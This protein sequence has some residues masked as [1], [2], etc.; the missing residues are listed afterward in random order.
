MDCKKAREKLSFYVYGEL[1]EG[2]KAPVDAHLQICGE[3]TRKLENYRVV[4]EALRSLPEAGPPGDFLVKVRSR[5]EEPITL[6]TRLD[7]LF[8][9]LAG[10]RLMAG[11]SV[12]TAAGLALLLGQ[13]QGGFFPAERFEAAA[14]SAAEAPVAAG[15]AAP[16]SMAAGDRDRAKKSRPASD[17]APVRAQVEAGKAAASAEEVAPSAAPG[18]GRSATQLAAAPRSRASAAPAAPP[19]PPRRDAAEAFDDDYGLPA[20]PARQV[21]EARRVPVASPRYEAPPESSPFLDGTVMARAVA[22]PPPRRAPAEVRSMD[23]AALA[24]ELERLQPSPP[25][26]PAG[27]D[28]SG[29]LSL[30]APE[31]AM[32]RLSPADGS[33]PDPRS[34]GAGLDRP[35]AGGL[36]GEA[37]ARVPFVPVSL[38]WVR[39]T[40]GRKVEVSSGPESGVEESVSRTLGLRTDDPRRLLAGLHDLVEAG[41]GLEIQRVVF[42]PDEEIEV[43]LRFGGPSSLDRFVED[44]QALPMAELASD[45]S[46]PSA[47]AVGGEGEATRAR[48]LIP[49]VSDLAAR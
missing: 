43:L 13:T 39:T 3:C 1:T 8:E 40:F 17:P 4:R 7:E 47:L 27:R 34:G 12:A 19:P 37:D 10:R 14:P 44:L 45:L 49:N 9:A 6:A 24:D 23:A 41:L 25:A 15:P 20:R 42:R 11:A 31:G 32:A 28:S 2:E 18:A 22:A 16:M 29:N 48:L 33:R 26:S 36:F 21:P 5:L 30:F 38:A 46:S 35:V